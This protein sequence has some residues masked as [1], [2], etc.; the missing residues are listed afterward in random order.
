MIS[1]NTNQNEKQQ[2]DINYV[3]NLDE[4]VK[5]LQNMAQDYSKQERDQD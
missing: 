1:V 5:D 3:E 2:K 4:G